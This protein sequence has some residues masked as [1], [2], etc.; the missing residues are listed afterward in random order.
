MNAFEVQ[1]TVS[2]Y[3]I[4][5]N[6]KYSNITRQIQVNNEFLLVCISDFKREMM[7]RMKPACEKC[8][9]GLFMEDLLI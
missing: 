6:D 8:Q 5:T 7:H 2:I 4:H 3:S 9:T 1:G